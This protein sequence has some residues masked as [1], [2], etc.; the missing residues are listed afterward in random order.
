[1]LLGNL[2]A[3]LLGNMLTSKGVK[4]TS[5]GQKV[6]G[7]EGEGTISWKGFLTLAHPLTSFEIQS[8]QNEP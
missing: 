5:Q 2:D 1:M 3:S 4:I 7:K 6:M 8:Y